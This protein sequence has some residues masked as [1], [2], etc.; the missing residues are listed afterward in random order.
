MTAT[1]AQ[2]FRIEWCGNVQVHVPLPVPV[3][4]VFK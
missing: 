1:P 4:P 3:K 2:E